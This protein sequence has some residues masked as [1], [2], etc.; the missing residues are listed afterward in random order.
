MVITLTLNPALDRTAAVPAVRPGTLHRLQ[1][2][3]TDIGGKGI[4]VSRA[5]AALGGRTLACGFAAGQ[6]GRFLCAAL[7]RQG[8][9]HDFVTLPGQTRTNLKLVTPDG[10]LTEFNEP[11]PAA[12]PRDIEVL[13]QRLEALARPGVLFVL[14]GSAGPGVPADIYA[15][16]TARLK[17]RG[18]AVLV[19]ADGPLLAAALEGT[20]PPDIVK[21]NAGELAGYLGLDAA[22]LAPDRLPDLAQTLLARGVGTV[23]VS[24]GAKGAA[25]FTQNGGWYAPAVPIPV[26]STV[27]AGDTMAAAL[28]LGRQQGM[29]PP[30]SLRLA[31][32]AAAAA[33]MLPGTC[34]PDRAAAE[35]LAERVE[36]QALS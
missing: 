4:N 5:V 20:V 12:A 9:P 36:I 35:A 26:Q 2:L 28:A 19:D 31:V 13:A 32:A 34:P 23:C 18:A 3:R 17:G 24:L 33:C 10:A 30:A 22:A 11:G 16:L 29:A 21:P 8:I 15:S 7:D 1:A 14:A 6:A 27:G 25:L